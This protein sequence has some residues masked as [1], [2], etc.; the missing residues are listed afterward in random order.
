MLGKDLGATNVMLWD[1]EDRLVAALNITVT[2]DLDSLKKQ[3]ATVLPGENV[4]L[5]SAQRNIVLS[6]QVSSAAKMDAALQVARGYLEQM[7]TAKE[8][9]MFKQQTRRAAAT[10]PT[11]NPAR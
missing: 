8:K 11:R 3:I 9:I 4:E 7:A 6:G 10:S 2:H 5:W 1:R